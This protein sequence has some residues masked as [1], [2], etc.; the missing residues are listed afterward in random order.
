VLVTLRACCQEGPEQNSEV[1][2]ALSR[3]MV[4]QV[5]VKD[6]GQLTDFEPRPNEPRA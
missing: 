5:A 4:L 2:G 3:Q 6:I 1:L